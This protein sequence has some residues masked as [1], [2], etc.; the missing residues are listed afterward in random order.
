MADQDTGWVRAH[1]DDEDIWLQ[2]DQSPTQQVDIAIHNHY[3]R[4]YLKS[5]MRV[6]EMGA[7]AGRFTRTIA[8]I[9]RPIVVADLSA[10]KLALNKRNAEA[11]GHASA[12]EDWRE[13]DMTDIKAQFDND[14]FDAVVCVGGP[15]SYVI[16]RREKAV[17]ELYRVTKPGGL[18]FLS[19]RSLFGTLHESLPRILNVNPRINREIIE[20]GNM[21]P[22]Q[23]SLAS[24]F[25]HAY[26]AQEFRA[27]VEATGAR[28]LTITASNCLSSTW[29]DVLTAWRA[30]R[31]TW[32]HL[33]ELEIAACREP[34]CL[35]M[36][37]HVLVVA[38]KP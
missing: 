38:Q 2:P 3:L 14:Q 27:F 4:Q 6:L 35:D 30:D 10:D 20:T 36:G 23:V 16:D 1:S 11:L 8:A 15:L 26:R 29:T 17:N 33:I 32:E 21:G 24:R 34:G 12:I 22:Q 13:C 7:G 25:W 18:L 19:A 31:R 9:T 5:G 28:T 37:A